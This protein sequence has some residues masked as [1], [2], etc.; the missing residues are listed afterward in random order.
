MAAKPET[1][2]IGKLHK[3]LPK[4]VYRMKNHNLYTGGIPDCYYSGSKADLWIEYKFVPKLPIK[5]P[6]RITELLSA[7]QTEWLKDRHSEG[8]NLAVIIGCPGGG[9]LLRNREWETDI[10][11]SH[12]KSLIRSNDDLAEW[13]KGQVE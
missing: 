6:L 13:I 7:L 8:R 4:S 12:L 1:T 2:Y 5:V 11:V 3:K 9:I 10:P